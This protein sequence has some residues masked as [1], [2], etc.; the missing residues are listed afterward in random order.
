MCFRFAQP[1]DPKWRH[2]P[3]WATRIINDWRKECNI[4]PL[5]FE[6]PEVRAVFAAIADQLEAEAQE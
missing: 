3:M 5:L 4:R 1:R 2:W 6:M